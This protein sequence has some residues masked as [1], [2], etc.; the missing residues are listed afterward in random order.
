MSRDGNPMASVHTTRTM[1]INYL[2]I[3]DDF[4]SGHVTQKPFQRASSSLF[5]FED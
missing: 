2:F 4:G 3:C 5:L 1:Q